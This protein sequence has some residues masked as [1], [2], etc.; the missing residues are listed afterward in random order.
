MSLPTGPISPRPVTIA[1]IGSLALLLL[2][3]TVRLAAADSPPVPGRYTVDAWYADDGLPQQLVTASVQTGD[4]YLWLGTD[5]GLARFDG[6]RFSTF[7]RRN[8][9]EFADGGRIASLATAPDGSLWIGTDT[10]GLIHL[11]GG[12]FRRVWPAPGPAPRVRDIVVDR[13]GVVWIATP[14][15]LVRI[16]RGAVRQFG[17]TDGLATR[18]PRSIY[19]DRAGTLFVGSRGAVH[20]LRDGRFELAARLPAASVIGFTSDRE[21]TLWIG[22]WGRGAFRLR[23]TSVERVPVDRA[24]EGAFVC[25]FLVD[26]EGHV[27]VG[28]ATGL[29]RLDAGVLRSDP[30]TTALGQVDVNSLL[31]DRDGTLWVGTTAGLRRLRKTAL[32]RLAT[33]DGLSHQVVLSISRGRDGSVWIGTHGGGLNRV[34]DGRVQRF[35]A[36]AGLPQQPITAI[37]EDRAGVMWVGT[38]RGLYVRDKRTWRRATELGLAAAETVRTL[39]EDRQGT[40]WIGTDKGLV[41]LSGGRTTIFTAPRDLPDSTVLALLEARRRHA[42]G[43][44]RRAASPAFGMVASRRRRSATGSLTTSSRR[45]TRTRSARCGSAPITASRAWRRGRPPSTPRGTA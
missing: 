16:D 39:L 26:R 42:S 11:A 40:I 3:G 13:H 5:D 36:A 31:E 37:L 14:D 38:E 29:K 2:S 27:W 23:G 7:D 25:S 17:P 8:T 6:V 43:S 24:D 19:I 9:P 35:G 34:V 30:A 10:D 44:A 4:G 18:S 32:S 12:R 20:R 21:G 15:G 22:T 33:A 1:W 45:C 41:R 28:T